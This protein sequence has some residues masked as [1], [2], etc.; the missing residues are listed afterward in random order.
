[1]ASYRKS[2]R[3]YGEKDGIKWNVCLCRMKRFRFYLFNKMHFII[4]Y[5]SLEDIKNNIL[6]EQTI[7]KY[8]I[9]LKRA[10]NSFEYMNVRLLYSN[11]RHVSTT[12]VSVFKAERQRIRPLATLKK[13]TGGEQTCR[14]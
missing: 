8:I 1:V 13:V 5:I 9:F 11:H 6:I 7:E 12:S 3:Q 14:W 2:E 4:T 10:T